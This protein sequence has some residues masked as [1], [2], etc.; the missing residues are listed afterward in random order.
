MSKAPI[1]KK[2]RC[3]L[4]HTYC[5]VG[6]TMHA[7]CRKTIRQIAEAH[8]GDSSPQYSGK[9]EAALRERRLMKKCHVD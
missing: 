8:A 3:T 6:L 2:K 1:P 4:C 5:A 9:Q 7:A